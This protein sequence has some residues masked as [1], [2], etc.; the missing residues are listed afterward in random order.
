MKTLRIFV[1]TLVSLLMLSGSVLAAGGSDYEDVPIGHW[2]AG[3]IASCAEKGLMNG[4]GSQR[5]SPDTYLT[6]AQ[7]CQVL[8][9]AYRDRL[10]DTLDQSVPIDGMTGQEWYNDAIRWALGNCI[11]T[12]KYHDMYM[13]S[14]VY[15]VNPDLP[16]TRQFTAMMIYRSAKLLVGSGLPELQPAIKFSDLDGLS[17]IQR[18][19]IEVLQRAGIIEGFPDGT[20][21]P[22]SPLTRAQAAVIFDRITDIDGMEL[23]NYH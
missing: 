11:F 8:Y 21:K 18:E 5:F 4:V 10:P 16:A 17:D 13:S 7:V 2:A 6:R 22:N 15:G 3:N 19:S 23:R 14:K 12:D 1:V 20:Y 9:N